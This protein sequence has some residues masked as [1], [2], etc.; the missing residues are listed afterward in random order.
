MKTLTRL[1]LFAAG[2]LSLALAAQPPAPTSERTSARPTRDQLLT[3]FTVMRI[4]A[5][6]EQMLSMMPAA[7]EQQMQSEEAE[8]RSTM[9]TMGGEPTPEQKT[10]VDAITAKY[11]ALAEKQYPVDDMLD[12]MVKVYQRHLTRDDVDGILAFYRS[13]AGQHLLD[14]QPLMAGE[15]MPVVMKK[16]EARDRELIER[17]KE[18][19]NGVFTPPKPASAP[20]KS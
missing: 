5:Q 17:Y 6:M 13:A 15:V 7:L 1:P 16:H 4:R 2:F 19:L 8:M 3:L 14:A 11:I 20:P 18:E 10:A 9:L 12:D